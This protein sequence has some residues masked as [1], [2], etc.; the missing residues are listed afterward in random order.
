MV[1]YLDLVLLLNFAVDYLL[2]LGTNRLGGYPGRQ[3]RSILA[4]AVG[5]IYAGACILPS[6]AFLGNTFWRLVCLAVMSLIAFGFSAL[7]LRQGAVFVLLSMALGGVAVGMGQTNLLGILAGALLILG[8]CLLGFYGKL[9]SKQLAEVKL[10][11]EKRQI[12]FMALRDT[13]NLLKDPI[14]GEAVLVADSVLARKLLGFSEEML[15][16]PITTM[17]AHPQ[18]RLRLIPY[19]SVGQSG[20]MLLALRVDAVWIDGKKAGTLVAFAPQ[21]L[22]NG[23]EYQALTGGVL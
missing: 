12:T 9:G 20:G 1:I 10:S 21:R 7:A 5:G 4:A 3:G 6:F 14:T 2:I 23:E 15:C 8:I 17:E 19:R 22:G 16:T 13:G 18:R 11:Y